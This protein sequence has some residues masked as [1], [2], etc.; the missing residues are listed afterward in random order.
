MALYKCWHRITQK[1]ILLIAI[2]LFPI[3]TGFIISRSS[4]ARPH[5]LAPNHCKPR[6]PKKTAFLNSLQRTSTNQKLP[7]YHGE[8][9]DE[10]KKSEIAFPSRGSVSFLSGLVIYSQTVFAADPSSVVYDANLN[11]FETQICSGTVI[12][13]TPSLLN[14]E[15][16][17]STPLYS[18]DRTNFDTSLSIASS[19]FPEVKPEKEEEVIRKAAERRARYKAEKIEKEERL[20]QLRIESAKIK[21][22][23]DEILAKKNAAI[24]QK[25]IDNQAARD[26]ALTKKTSELKKEAFEKKTQA[27]AELE[28]I[29]KLL[30]GVDSSKQEKGNAA[31]RKSVAGRKLA[32][33]IQEEI[34]AE[35][36]A[37]LE[38]AK[39]TA[40][41]S[42][43]KLL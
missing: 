41:E 30:N 14:T 4:P 22:I 36:R 38:N 29:E 10:K 25:S 42:W 13:S 28:E 40:S 43:P 26:A 32:S 20:Q 39:D 12:T 17:Y 1:I 6:P 23:N 33:A 35:S 27:I 2:S 15:I 9:L 37:K 11:G 8:S 7:I 24:A 3:S 21:A 34:T 31:S 18:F 19:V 16:S 5:V